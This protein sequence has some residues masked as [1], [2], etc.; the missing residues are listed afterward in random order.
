VSIS[1]VYRVLRENGYRV[2]KKTY[3][4]SLNT[5]NKE[6]RLEWCLA[7]SLEKGWDLER[8]KNIIWTDE[9]LVVLGTIRGKQ[10]V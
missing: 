1:I 4:P 8:W 6:K 5:I 9:T 3:K 10:R 2:F 7:H